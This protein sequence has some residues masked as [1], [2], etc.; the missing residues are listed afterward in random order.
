MHELGLGGIQVTEPCVDTAK[1]YIMLTCHVEFNVTI[2]FFQ[3][4]QPKVH[5]RHLNI[6]NSR[7]G[8]VMLLVFMHN[9]V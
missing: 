1:Y 8:K 6:D 3:P 2:P 5:M 9:V 4:H 7:N